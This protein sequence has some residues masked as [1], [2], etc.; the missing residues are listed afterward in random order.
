M[1]MMACSFLLARAQYAHPDL[2]SGKIVVRKVLIL[3][4]RASITEI[5]D[6]GQRILDRRITNGRRQPCRPI[7]SESQ[8]EKRAVRFCDNYI[9]ARGS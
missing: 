8:S 7:V 3:P 2:K 1:L 9:H 6:E 5:G 4:P